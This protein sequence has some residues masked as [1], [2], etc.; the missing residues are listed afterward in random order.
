MENQ[1]EMIRISLKIPGK[2]RELFPEIVMT[3]SSI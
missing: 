3:T 2:I 1:G